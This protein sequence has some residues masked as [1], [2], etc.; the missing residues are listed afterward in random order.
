MDNQL[1]ME[2]AIKGVLERIAKSGTK[3]T[4]EKMMKPYFLGCNYEEKSLTIGYDIEPWELNP[5]NVLHG[6][7]ITTAFDNVFG[8]LTH[9]FAGG[10][11]FVTT[12]EIGVHFHKP[13]FL[14]DKIVVTAKATHI[15]KTLAGY[16][17]ELRIPARDN[18]LA[19][20]ADTTFFVMNGKKSD[21]YKND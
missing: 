15:G 5:Q 17:G 8:T 13:V 10:N 7:I 3:D 4:V 6:G 1:Q 9:Y 21:L 19:A 16:T 14:G 20:T 11:T 2:N 12:V 18:V